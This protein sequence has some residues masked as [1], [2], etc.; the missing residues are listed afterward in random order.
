M[1]SQID[2]ISI[3]GFR[4]LAEVKIAQLPQAVVMVGANGSG[5]SNFIR[6]FEMVQQTLNEHKLGMFVSDQG[7]ADDQLFGGASTSEQIEATIS[8]RNKVGISQYHF[9][10]SFAQPD[11]LQFAK[12]LFR[13]VEEEC[14]E[15][16]FEK[17]RD[18]NSELG[19]QDLGNGHTEAKILEVAC[20]HSSD[21]GDNNCEWKG[22]CRAAKEVVNLFK[23]SSIF[24]F[25][26]TS[27]TSKMKIR[28]DIHDCLSLRPDG[29]N[30]ASVLHKLEKDNPLEYKSIH[31]DISQVLPD[32]GGFA[33][34]EE[35]GKVILRWKSLGTRKIFG[36]H[37]TS[38]GSLRF[39]ALATLL[40]LPPEM[41]PNV[42]FLDEPEL[43]LHPSAICLLG[44]MIQTLSRVTQVIL[45]TQ[46][47]LLVDEFDLD[48]IIV[49]DLK[50]GKTDMRQ[51]DEK[52]YKHWLE[53]YSTG[54]LWQK[55]VIGG[56]P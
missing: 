8:I 29:G 39:F 7:G 38:D 25:H 43:G 9:Q 46:S 48:E 56:R 12:E 34:Q 22:H 32:F 14:R 21:N 2:S 23:K 47:P 24:Q 11:R 33:I 16:Q 20:S 19:W 42:I 44:S 26:D 49:L 6:F 45:A 54:Q 52:N 36:A 31:R 35:N 4:S 27:D 18:S 3:N 13:F 50:D 5:K 30:L 37:L 28:W 10:L 40:N 53:E 55:N 1:S 51:L 15:T 41:L 17:G